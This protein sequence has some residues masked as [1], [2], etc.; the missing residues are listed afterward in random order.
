MTDLVLSID[1]PYAS[2]VMLG[3]KR[4][5]TRPSPP[6]GDMRPDGVRGLPGAAVNRGDRLLIASTTRWPA[7]FSTYGARFEV[8]P[9]DHSPMLYDSVADRA[10]NV[11]LGCI[12]GS[13][14][15]TDAYPIESI[16]PGGPEPSDASLLCGRVAYVG[17]DSLTLTDRFVSPPDD[18]DITDQLP[19]GEWDPGRWAWALAD[20][21][22]LA[23]PVPVVGRQGVW[24]WDGTVRS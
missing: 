12:L 3:H 13:V 5:E 21:Q 6:N 1:Q 2:L 9:H 17:G 16:E 4:F 8:W 23:E 18:T 22:P 20:P 14:E 11:P 19:L 10:F 7:N 24:R 15:V